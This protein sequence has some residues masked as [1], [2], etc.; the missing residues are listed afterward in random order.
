M[1]FRFYTKVRVRYSDTDAQGH[2]YFANYLAYF[3]IATTDYMK[4]IGYSYDKLLEENLDFF[5]V[6]TL[7]RY[8]GRAFFDDSLK[9][10]ARISKIGNSSFRYDL[11]I[12]KEDSGEMVADGY[13][14]NVMV[15]K[16]TEKPARV[17]DGFREAVKKFEGK[18]SS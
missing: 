16:N 17:P 12:T 1:D 3:D 8:K 9:V 15:D 13:I 6:E 4:A 7:C 2:V 5:T 10:F 18:F 11:A 14:V